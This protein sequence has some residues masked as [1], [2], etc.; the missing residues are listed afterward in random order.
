MEL[1]TT[2]HGTREYSKEDVIYFEKGLP[3]F[4]NLKEFI[5]FD[6]EKDSILSIL[7][8]VENPGIGL[9]VMSPFSKVKDYEFNLDDESALRLKIEKPEDV[10]VLNT[11]TLNSKVENITVNLRAPII[12][13]I[14]N[15]LGEQKILNDDKYEIKHPLFKEGV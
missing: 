5:I 2:F 6:V 3:G 10:V 7:Q 13:N 9:V 14:K 15:K 8:S 12:I 1:E 11:V 4:E